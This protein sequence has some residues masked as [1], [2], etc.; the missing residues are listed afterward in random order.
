ME[1]V[2]PLMQILAL[3]P[4]SRFSP[5]SGVLRLIY[6]I[7]GIRTDMILFNKNSRHN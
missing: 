4:C 1:I 2:K 5:S 7:S 6:F 3:G